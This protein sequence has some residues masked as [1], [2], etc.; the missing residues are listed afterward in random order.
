MKCHAESI[1]ANLSP[2]LS[3]AQRA[4]LEDRF[5]DDCIDDVNNTLHQYYYKAKPIFLLKTDFQ[6]AY[7]FINRDEILYILHQLDFSPDLIN[8]FKI[9]LAPS[10]MYIDIP[11]AP[12]Y[13]FENVTGVK[14]G[15]PISPYLYI[16]IFDLLIRKINENPK[17]L[18]ARAYM[19]DLGLLLENI[20]DISSY[21]ND[22]Q[23][24]CHAL[25][26]A[27]NYDKCSI[28]IPEYLTN[29]PPPIPAPWNASP[30]ETSTTYLGIKISQTNQDQAI[31]D[32]VLSKNQEN[33]IQNY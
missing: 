7:D 32:N 24:Y 3:T 10:P 31:W 23:T 5:I 28:L 8:I 16:L 9:A 15:C 26:A 1:R 25:G 29:P 12:I 6:K 11:G 2:H 22:F 18:L 17:T 33:P 14:Q 13:T 20:Q 27:L 19:D 21:T 30:I 4:L